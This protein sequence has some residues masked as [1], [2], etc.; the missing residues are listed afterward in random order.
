MTPISDAARLSF[1]H[2]R[3]DNCFWNRSRNADLFHYSSLWLF[4]RSVSSKIVALSFLVEPNAFPFELLRQAAIQQS[5][6]VTSFGII[7]GVCP[8]CSRH[9]LN[10][11]AVADFTPWRLRKV[12]KR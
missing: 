11:S 4:C 8:F 3:P 7:F 12:M 9:G 5:N 10:V 2:V 6:K 1:A